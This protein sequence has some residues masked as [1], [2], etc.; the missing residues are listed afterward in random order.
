MAFNGGGD[1]TN[2]TSGAPSACAGDP[3][4]SGA[5]C[6]GCHS[7]GPAVTTLSGIFSS[8]IPPAGYT[9]STTY[10][11]TANFVRPGHVKFGFEATPQNT[12]GTLK[13]TMANINAQTKLILSNKYITHTSSGVSGSGSKL[14][15]FTWTAP[16][17][18]Q[19]PVTFYGMFN[20]TNNNGSDSGDSIFKATM[21][22]T[23]NTTAVQNPNPEIFSFSTYPN[24]VSDFLNVKFYL[25]ETSSA[26]MELFD[27]R[28]NKIA[29]LLSETEL[30]GEMDKSFDISSYPQGIYFLRL[31]VN[32]NSS[33]KKIIKM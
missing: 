32:E 8:N 33:L 30:S 18:G 14:W 15:S 4:S 12:A 23:E 5:T 29:A 10:T 19:G 25:A 22:M 20:A 3:A 31:N 17:T 27:I 2:S 24:P 9:P 28:G 11:I 26:E 21:V 13:G 6:K 7:P 1:E 16:A